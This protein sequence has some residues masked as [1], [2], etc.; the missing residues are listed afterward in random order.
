MRDRRLRPCGAIRSGTER[1]RH[2]PEHTSRHPQVHGPG[3]P[4]RATRRDQ[5]RSLQDGRYVFPRAGPVGDV[6][7]LRDRR[8][9]AAGGAVRA[10]VRG[11]RA[12]GPV[13]RGH[14]RG[15]GGAGPAP[16]RARA[17][18]RRRAA[19]HSGDAHVGMLARQPPGAAHGSESQKDPREI[20]HR[21]HAQTRVTR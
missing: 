15:G 16:A 20:Q 10:A 3:S 17:V 11:A 5:L 6:P 19:V 7:A 4:R 18:D 13:V 12:A 1:S 21:D 2:R 9:G 8:Q 14:A